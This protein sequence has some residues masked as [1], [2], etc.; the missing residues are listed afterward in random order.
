MNTL[1]ISLFLLNYHF[2]SVIKC[3]ENKNIHRASA[4]AKYLDK[5]DV[6]VEEKE[7]ITCWHC[8]ALPSM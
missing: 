2:I 1:A 8:A 5:N 3:E 6:S 4:N 7:S